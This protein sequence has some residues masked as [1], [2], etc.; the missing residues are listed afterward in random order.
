MPHLDEVE[1]LEKKF[2]YESLIK[3]AL[4][5]IEVMILSDGEEEKNDLL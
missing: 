5:N 3:E 2:D 1:A 4:A